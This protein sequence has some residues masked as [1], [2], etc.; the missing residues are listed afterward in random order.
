[1]INPNSFPFS[2]KKKPRHINDSLGNS[3]VPRVIS[4][5]CHTSSLMILWA[6][7]I[8]NSYDKCKQ[9]RHPSQGNEM[10]KGRLTAYRKKIRFPGLLIS[11]KVQT[12]RLCD[13]F[14]V[15]A[16]VSIYHPVCRST[17]LGGG[18]L[19]LRTTARLP[20]LHFS[21]RHLFSGCPF[22]RTLPT[23]RGRA[24]RDDILG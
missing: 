11:V 17:R 6:Q 8:V 5:G 23:D 14:P 21:K 3:G 10:G 4:N 7:E 2:L 22:T 19:A 12:S 18:R 1:L 13:V 9:F 16:N 24:S 20:A 15:V